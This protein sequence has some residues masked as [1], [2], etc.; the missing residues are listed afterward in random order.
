MHN[1]GR[2][3]QA[4]QGRPALGVPEQPSALARVLYSAATV[5]YAADGIDETLRTALDLVCA[6]TGWPLGHLHRFDTDRGALVSTPLWHVDDAPGYQDFVKAI[7][8]ASTHAGSGFLARILASGA[9]MSMSDVRSDPDLAEAVAAA[10]CEIGSAFGFPIVGAHGIQGVMEFFSATPGAADPAL[11]EAVSQLGIQLGAALDR[12]QAQAER[13]RLAASRDASEERLAEAQ[14]IACMGS[15]SWIVGEDRVHWSSQLHRIYGVEEGGGP[16]AFDEYLARVH[17]D[18]RERVQSAVENTLATLEPYEHEYRIVRPDGVVRWVHARGEVTARD[19][20]T[21][22]RLGGYCQDITERRET[23]ALVSQAHLELFNQQRVL[24][25]IARAEPVIDNLALL[26]QD[27][28]AAYP[29]ALCTVLLADDSGRLLHAAAPSLPATFTDALN[30]LRI[31][32]GMGAC[33]TAAARRQVVIVEDIDAN[34]LTADYLDVAR[35]HGIRSVWSQPLASADGVVL[36]TF[37]VYRSVTHQPDTA[38]LLTVSA[39]ANL[40]ALAIERDRIEQALTTA[41]RS[42]PVTGLPNRARFLELLAE[43]LAGSRAPATVMLLDLDRFKWINDGLGHPAGDRILVE[44]AARLHRAAAGRA[45][46]ARFGGDQF[47]ILV[48]EATADVEAIADD[49]RASFADPFVLDGGEFHLT[50]SIG[51]AASTATSDAFGLVRDADAAMY[52]AKESGRSR[53]AR[54]DAT[55]RERAVRRVTLEAEI[56]RGIALGEFTMHYQPI[57]DL[58]SGRWVGAE[59]LVRWRHGNGSVVEPDAFIPLAE[60]TGLILPLGALILDQVIAQGARW[61]AQGLAHVLAANVSVLQLT[62]PSFPAVLTAGLQRHG[63]R[64]DLLTVEVTESAVMDR[65]DDATVALRTIAAGGTSIAIDD[66]GTGHSSI[67]RIREL[68]VAS[69]KIDRRFVAALGT[70]P[71]ADNV[72]SAMA[73]LAHALGL[74]VTAEGVETADH[75]AR[76]AA[77]GCDFAQGYHLSPPLPADDAVRVLTAPLLL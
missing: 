13:E 60:E 11:G 63:L 71:S 41:A 27:V 14:R 38:E 42:D 55:L 19:G 76:V 56:R 25:R 52:A 68:P 72:L 28:E 7:D 40:A 37:A 50:A 48:D 4:A 12:A 43:R 64:A 6:C 69:V 29:G 3:R 57:L 33:G 75:L 2:T 18:D 67:A 35:Q 24:E 31:A 65:L 32:E 39:S 66:F 59:A 74:R 73:D 21:P 8:H 77:L 45:A 1:R 49:F 34:P 30:G 58:H 61:A 9:A 51:I 36:G 10:P 5:A 70:Y 47:A 44:V 46:V 53:R 23:E 54:F 20:D 62:D 16:V 15:W 17:P 22:R 26:C